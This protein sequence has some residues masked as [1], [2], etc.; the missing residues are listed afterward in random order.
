M[1]DSTSIVEQSLKESRNNK[2]KF[3]YDRKLTDFDITMGLIKYLSKVGKNTKRL[4]ILNSEDHIIDTFSDFNHIFSD[5]KHTDDFAEIEH[6]YEIFSIYDSDLSKN[7][8]KLK[9]IKYVI[10]LNEPGYVEEEYISNIINDDV[11]QV[12]FISNKEGFSNGQFLRDILGIFKERRTLSIDLSHYRDLS[13]VD[14][15]ELKNMCEID[16]LL[17]AANNN[18]SEMKLIESFIKNF[19]SIKSLDLRNNDISVVNLKHM[20]EL[21]TLDIRDN[22]RP[23]RIL[24]AGKLKVLKISNFLNINEKDMDNESNI[25]PTVYISFSG[26]QYLLRIEI[27]GSFRYYDGFCKTIFDRFQ[28]LQ[29]IIINNESFFR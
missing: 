3:F 14:E 19:N 16:L 26:K 25:I 10:F 27:E 2:I 5:Y 12:I 13:I 7:K 11:I 1:L 4:I 6:Y 24:D 8:K 15:L 9:D 22:Y 18:I 21:T 28:S 29:E 23:R 20:Q 17:K